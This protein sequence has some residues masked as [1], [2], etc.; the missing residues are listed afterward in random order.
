MKPVQQLTDQEINEELALLLHGGEQKPNDYTGNS[1]MSAVLRAQMVQRGWSY[2]I[3][4]SLELRDEGHCYSCFFEKDG[5]STRG[6]YINERRA[7]AVAALKALRSEAKVEP[8][9]KSQI[10]ICDKFDIDTPTLK[11]CGNRFLV[12]C[13]AN[14]RFYPIDLNTDPLKLLQVFS[15]AT[16]FSFESVSVRSTKEDGAIIMNAWLEVG[17]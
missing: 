3:N 11:R 14:Q 13:Q 8:E 17:R 10:V 4:S 7:V 15:N 5:R 6:L 12:Q 9:E 2:E 16:F 1:G